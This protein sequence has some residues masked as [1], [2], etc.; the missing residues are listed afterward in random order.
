MQEIT[1]NVYMESQFPPHNL[2]AIVTGAGV[3]AV[4][5]PPCPSHARAWLEVLQ[6]TWG[7]PR[8][9]VLTDATPER[10]IG[11]ALWPIPTIVSEATKQR[12]RAFDDKTWAD[13]V[14]SVGQTFPEELDELAALTPPHPT[15]AIGRSLHLHYSS[16]PLTL[17]LGSGHAQGSLMLFDPEHQVLFAGDSVVVNHPPDVQNTPDFGAWLKTLSALARRKDLGWIVPGRGTHPI[18]RGDLETQREIMHALDHAAG[19]LARKGDI[20]DGVAQLTTDLQQAFYPHAARNSAIHTVLRRDLEILAT[21]KRAQR[22]Q[23]AAQKA[24]HQRPVTDPASGQVDGEPE[25]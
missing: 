14:H 21:R 16:P 3:I 20:T 17:Q 18:T 15:L 25:R 5:A 6:S 19:R 22:L 13:M 8:F 12:I 24:E 9:L 2:G 7:E 1:P 10:L 23:T 4:D 11:A